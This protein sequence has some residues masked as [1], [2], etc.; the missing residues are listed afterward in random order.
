MLNAYNARNDT[1]A[2]VKGIQR[3]DSGY[4]II[5]DDITS[6]SQ[7]DLYIVWGIKSYTV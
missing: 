4:T 3:R 5:F 7:V 6:S 1:V 2:T